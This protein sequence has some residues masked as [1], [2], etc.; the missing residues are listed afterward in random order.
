LT[1]GVR[2]QERLVTTCDR[3]PQQPRP[4]SDS[5][6]Q[7]YARAN[8]RRPRSW[9]VGRGRDL[10]GRA[11]LMGAGLSARDRLENVPAISC[12]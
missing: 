12:F 3:G 1:E 7:P 8:V 11:T 4:G 5:E 6:A 9:T 10:S 2:G